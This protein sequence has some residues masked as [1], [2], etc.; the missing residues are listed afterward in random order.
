DGTRKC[1]RWIP[2]RSSGRST[3]PPASWRS[4]PTTGVYS[5]VAAWDSGPSPSGG[6][7]SPTGGAPSRTTSP[8]SGGT[9]RSIAQSRSGPAWP[10][11]PERVGERAHGLAEGRT[12][13]RASL[14]TGV[15]AQGAHYGDDARHLA[16]GTED[17]A[18]RRRLC[19]RAAAG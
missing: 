14:L 2:A 10:S 16:R 5:R 7:D 15:P 9:C 12:R 13:P 3:A 4:I 19:P 18:P 11:E 6:T 8:T 1:P 17:S